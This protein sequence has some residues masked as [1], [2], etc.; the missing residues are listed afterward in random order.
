MFTT[1]TTAQAQTR[2]GVGIDISASTQTQSLGESVVDVSF[3]PFMREVNV[4]FNCIRLKPNTVVY[5]F[6]DGE[7]VSAH[8]T[9]S[10]GTLGGTITTDANGTCFGQF[11]IPSGQF[12]TGVKL[13]KL[14][15]D[16]NN[17]DSL[18]R[19]SST[20]NYAVRNQINYPQNSKVF[21]S[22]TTCYD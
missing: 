17:N 22:I 3:S 16:S 9:N 2:T 6:F 5:P 20:S 14:T 19:T 4:V 18:S 10:A 21:S 1:T 13:F 8:V 7:D 11:L 12:R 15:D